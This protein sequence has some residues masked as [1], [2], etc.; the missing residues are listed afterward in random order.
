[1]GLRLDL[2]LLR[3]QILKF[4]SEKGVQSKF[5]IIGVIPERH[6]CR[7]LHEAHTD[8]LLHNVFA[9]KM[10]WHQIVFLIIVRIITALLVLIPNVTE[11][12]PAMVV[13]SRKHV[14]FTDVCD[15]LRVLK[16]A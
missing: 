1:M 4:T 15:I 11:P 10:R 9:H 14:L 2:G 16:P 12:V 3:W 13:T 8:K 6:P 5:K 7:L